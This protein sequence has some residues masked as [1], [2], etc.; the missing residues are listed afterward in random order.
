MG[1]DVDL[2]FRVSMI[3]VIISY[4]HSVASSSRARTRLVSPLELVWM[5]AA[6]SEPLTDPWCLSRWS[7]A[8]AAD[9]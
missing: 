4:S 5:P 1:S 9:L 7:N 2:H 8:R 3:T 6:T